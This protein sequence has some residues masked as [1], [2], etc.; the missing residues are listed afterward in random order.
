MLSIGKL[1]Q[2]Q[3]DYFKRRRRLADTIEWLMAVFASQSPGAQDDL[4]LIDSTPIECARRSA[5]SRD[6]VGTRSTFAPPPTQPQRPAFA[7]FPYAPERIRTSDLRFRSGISHARRLSSYG[8]KKP[9]LAGR[10]HLRLP[11][12]TDR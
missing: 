11:P 10:T 1:G 9:R 5:S 3:A 2:G 7:S 6:I 12:V 4:L 8:A